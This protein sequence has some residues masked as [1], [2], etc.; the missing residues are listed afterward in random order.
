MAPKPITREIVG[1]RRARR[2]LAAISWLV[3]CWYATPTHASGYKVEDQSAAATAR[4]NAVVA[5]LDDAST[6]HYN[7]AGLAYMKGLSLLVGSQFVVPKFRYS[8]PE[9]KRGSANLVTGVAVLPSFFISHSLGKQHEWAVGF[10]VY[11]PFGIK[12]EYP[13][14]WAGDS[15]LQSIDLQT[16]Y[17]SPA[18]AYRP[19][20]YVSIGA[21]FNFVLCR[22]ELHRNLRIPND[23]GVIAG[24][25]GL[26]GRGFTFN[27][28]IGV[29][30]R[31]IDKL[32]IGLVYKTQG[33][34]KAKGNADFT[35]P[36]IFKPGLR[37]QSISTR[38]FLPNQFQIGVG[39][40]VLPQLY[41]EAGFEMTF[42]SLV[43][44]IVIRFDEPLFGTQ[45]AEILPTRWHNTWSVRLGFEARPVSFLKL[46]AGFAY[47][48]N[49]IPDQT[50]TPVL[51]DADRIEASFGIGYLHKNTGIFLDVSYM[52]V[53]L[54]KRTVSAEVAE[55]GFPQHYN[56]QIHL[57]GVTLGLRR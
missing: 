41:L 54:R 4:A 23:A 15:I 33:Y 22:V 9:G 31:P 10:G 13:T 37:D 47:D 35:V 17:F 48:R 18:V 49:P 43:H 1:W 45:D 50:L 30:I 11:A 14:T 20:K 44:N 56:S 34:V 25:V 19:V 51:P 26:G 46:R 38:L 36:E 8:D 52:A 57:I 16:I 27:A 3:S 7:P 28:T 12:L 32:Y 29:Q 39:Y 55:S 24:D 21:T 40:Q 6:V 42:W 5:R 2:T 53:I